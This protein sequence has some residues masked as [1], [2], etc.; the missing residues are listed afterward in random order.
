ML[1]WYLS[2][3]PGSSLQNQ[4]DMRCHPSPQGAVSWMDKQMEDLVTMDHKFPGS[5]GR[6]PWRPFNLTQWSSSLLPL[7]FPSV[8]FIYWAVP[9]I[10]H[11]ILSIIPDVQF[12]SQAQLFVTPWTVARQASLSFTISQSLLK[13][14]FT[15]S[16]V[17]SNHL[18][19]CCPLLLLLSIFPS[20]RVF[21]CES[22]LHIRWPKYWSFSISPSTEYSRLITFRIDCSQ[23]INWSIWSPCSPK[24]SQESFLAPQFKNINSSVL[25]LLYGHP[26][27]TFRK[28]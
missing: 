27:M 25:S 28:P 21:S 2:V 4:E 5:L 19:L 26:Y 20:I 3:V 8:L 22:A 14:M 18:F 12:L 13:L 10:S 11:E 17:P 15:E 6:G 24:D 16:V 23:L 7:C 9:I 1:L